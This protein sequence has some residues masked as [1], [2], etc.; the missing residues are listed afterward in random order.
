MTIIRSSNRH[1][2]MHYVTQVVQRNIC[3]LP[4]RHRCF[5]LIV[6]IL[7]PQY[8]AAVIKQVL[9]LTVVYFDGSF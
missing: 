1:I 2:L 5:C 8:A 7:R 3:N 4:H 9:L 6:I